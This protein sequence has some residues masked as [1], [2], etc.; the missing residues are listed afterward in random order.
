MKK[1]LLAGVAVLFLAT[2]TAHATGPD[3]CAVVSKTSDGFLNVRKAPTMKSEIIAKIHPGDLVHADAYECLITDDCEIK[4]WTHIDS[5]LRSS[6]REK[7]QELRG[8]VSS[9][10]LKGRPGLYSTCTGLGRVLIKR[11]AA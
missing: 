4:N 7:P 11:L 9:K 10:F 6:G 8:W 1:L 3:Y 5:V 2:G